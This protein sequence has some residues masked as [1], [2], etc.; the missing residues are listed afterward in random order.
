MSAEAEIGPAQR[1]QWVSA[2]IRGLNERSAGVRANS[3]TRLSWR[4]VFELPF[5][6]TIEYRTHQ[7]EL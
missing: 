1:L 2:S 3:V 4:I 5:W 6:G 7:S